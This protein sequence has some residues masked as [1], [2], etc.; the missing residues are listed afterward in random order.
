MK[1]GYSHFGTENLLKNKG[2]VRFAWLL[3]SFPRRR[4]S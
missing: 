4:E 1:R 3:P 2:K